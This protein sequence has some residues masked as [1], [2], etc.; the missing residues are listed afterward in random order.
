M[1]MRFVMH[2]ANVRRY[3]SAQESLFRL[4]IITRR[5]VWDTATRWAINDAM[6][7]SRIIEA[8]LGVRE[9]ISIGCDG[10]GRHVKSMGGSYRSIRRYGIE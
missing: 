7:G 4:S 3:A 5:H 6:W 1:H 9:K 10:R 2:I 8:V